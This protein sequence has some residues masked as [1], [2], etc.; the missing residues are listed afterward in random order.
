MESN[1]L[2]NKLDMLSSILPN[3]D[4]LTT[5]YVEREAVISSQIEGTQSSLSDVF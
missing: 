4:T 1:V 5:K 2:L 3:K